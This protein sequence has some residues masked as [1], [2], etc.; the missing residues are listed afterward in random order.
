MSAPSPE[1]CK[2]QADPHTPAYN[3]SFG[4]NTDKLHYLLKFS[5]S[6]VKDYTT[7]LTALSTELRHSLAPQAAQADKIL[8]L[9]QRMLE[10]VQEVTGGILLIHELMPV[11][12][13]TV[14][15]AYLKDVLV[16]AAGI[17]PSLMERTEQTASYQ[18]A[19]NVKSLEDLLL[20]FRSKWARRFVD[21]GGPTTW[22]KSLEAMGAKDYHP[23]TVGRMETLWGVRH[24]IVHYAGIATQDFIRRYPYLNAQ[25][26][27]RFIVNSGHLSEWSKGMYDFVEVTDRYFVQR[28][29][30]SQK[31]PS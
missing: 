11:L 25:V 20:Q 27:Q 22:I 15:E 3:N 23:E 10:P 19:L 28:C 18:D 5:H 6:A 30:K 29:Q 4:P 13:V 14:A 21:N 9:A 31:L 26:D 7:R 17:D 2:G 8:G 1:T 12:F 24:L 16:F